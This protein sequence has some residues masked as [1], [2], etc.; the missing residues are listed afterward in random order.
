MQSS[1]ILANVQIPVKQLSVDNVHYVIGQDVVTGKP[2]IRPT[3]AVSWLDPDDWEA[4]GDKHNPS[5][6]EVGVT[7][8]TLNK[9][10]KEKIKVSYGSRRP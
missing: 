7:N 3:M 2:I 1:L 9:D 8:I 4:S 5:Y 10:N 6:Y